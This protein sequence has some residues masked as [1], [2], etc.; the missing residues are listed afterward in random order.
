MFALKACAIADRR[1]KLTTVAP[2]LVLE[3]IL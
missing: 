3:T 1:F 2:A